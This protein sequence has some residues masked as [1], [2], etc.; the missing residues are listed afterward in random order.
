MLIRPI[1]QEDRLL[2][3]KLI[4]HPVQSWEWGE[5]RRK[6]GHAVERIGFFQGKKL[7]KAFQVF[8]HK[9]PFGPYTIGYFPRG[10]IP[11]D[12]QLSTLRHLAKKHNA[13]FIKI[14][15]NVA[16]KVDA[17]SAHAQIAK[18]LAEHDCFPGR[19]FFAKH[20]FFID[21]K[22][23]EATLFSRVSSKTRY[24]INLAF[25]KG[26]QIVED[27]SREGMEEYITILQETTSRQGFY[28][29][30]P[31]YFRNIWEVLGGSGMIRIFHATL[32]GQ[33]LVS[34]V[35]FM[36]NNVL[37]YPYGAS[38]SLNR[39]AMPSNL[40]MWEMIKFGKAN[41]CTFFD[42]WGCLGPD[43]KESD[44]FFGFH[45]FKKGYGGDLMEFLGSYD[46][47]IHPQLY[48]IY[49]LLENWR[50]KFLKMKARLHI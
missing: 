20:T 37:Y 17:P 19:P 42:L 47:V 32:D 8:F 9:L 13:L 40:M 48:K 24:N 38:R 46:L 4:A 43:A 28:A 16:A 41:N 45:R 23:D 2:Y 50:W 44:S 7:K 10:P 25:R 35:M 3:N 6:S 30:T 22:A 26:V 33:V 14:E 12:E 29:H 1:T 39:E 15:P 31:S 18:V 36:L 27:T 49:R 11:D 21:L 34:W 5:F